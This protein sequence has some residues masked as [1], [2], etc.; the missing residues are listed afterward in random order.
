MV[1]LNTGANFYKSDFTL[2]KYLFVLSEKQRDINSYLKL[3]NIENVYSTFNNIFNLGKII[4]KDSNSESIQ[5][6][7]KENPNFEGFN[8][9][10]LD[11]ITD[12]D[13]SLRFLRMLFNILYL[14]PVCVLAY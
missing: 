9:R 14:Y 2:L 12:P 3:S 7:P 1:F 6:E 4:E 13:R 11:N 10:N 8:F 5:E